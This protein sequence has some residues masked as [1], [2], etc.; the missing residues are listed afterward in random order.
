M[1]CMM[2]LVRKTMSRFFCDLGFEKEKKKFF[3]RINNYVVVLEISKESNYTLIEGDYHVITHLK[4]YNVYISI[5]HEIEIEAYSMTRRDMGAFYPL[6]VISN[7]DQSEWL[8]NNPNI[9]ESIE[10]TFLK[11]V[12]EPIFVLQNMFA[13]IYGL[14]LKRFGEPRVDTDTL[15]MASYEE[16]QYDITKKCLHTNL[17]IMFDPYCR[18]CISKYDDLTIEDLI[19]KIESSGRTLSKSDSILFCKYKEILLDLETK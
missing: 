1:R 11:F 18:D 5:Y 3:K 19:S 16:K 15:L 8:S 2:S 13:F 12:Y 9:C 17:A 14:G 4:Y 10:N 6:T 7:T